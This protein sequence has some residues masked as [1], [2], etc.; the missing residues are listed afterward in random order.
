MNHFLT[1]LVRCRAVLVLAILPLLANAPALADA[2]SDCFPHRIASFQV[3]TVSSPPAFNTW[4]PGIVFGPPGDATP[5]TGSLSV[6]SLGKGGEIV[7]EF[8]ESEIVDGAGPDF[9]VFENPF[10]CTAVPQSATGPYSVFAEPGIVAVSDDGVNFRTVPF[11][12]AALSQV[13]SG[14][15]DKVLLQ[16]LIGLAGIT[17][18]FTGNYTIPD[19]PLVFDPTA[20]G[21]V[22][23]HGGDAF[24][25]AT[26]G[27]AHARFVR[28]TD[29]SLPTGIPGSSEGFDL[30]AVVALHARPLL[31]LGQLD[32]DGDGL[33][34][35]AE[36]FLYHTDP[37]RPDTDGDGV[38][39]GEEAATCR[40][41]LASDPDPFFLPIVELE[42]AQPS[43]TLLRWNFLG[44]GVTYDAVR[45][46]VGA[47]RSVGGM[48]DLG[49]VTCIENDSTDLTTRGLE[50]AAVPLPGEAFFYAVRANAAGGFGY[51]LSSAHEPRVPASGDCK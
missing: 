14:C 33:S 10:F 37:A 17:P 23:G 39:D 47:L 43:P 19:D 34:D 41:P 13:G 28:I 26:V 27:L 11:N 35:E 46:G 22:S 18:N 20:P 32:T 6:M 31:G 42:V 45:G 29:P 7:L 40:N 36:A 15:T 48:V 24:D 51:G 16:R 38:P 49:V 12:T 9:I 3:G 1:A 5:T 4:Q 25:L 8:D 2:T 50:D 30:D 21:G 44:T